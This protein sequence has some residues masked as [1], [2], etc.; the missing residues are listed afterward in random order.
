MGSANLT[1][2]IW[3]IANVPG[4]EEMVAKKSAIMQV[5]SNGKTRVMPAWKGRLS[6]TEIKILTFYVHDLGGGK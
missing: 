5:V 4:S 6:D 2:S 3:T 1:D